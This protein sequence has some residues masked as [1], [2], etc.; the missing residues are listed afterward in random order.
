MRT[1]HSILFQHNITTQ[2]AP[3]V[4]KR[5]HVMI[6][7]IPRMEKAFTKALEDPK[8]PGMG[9]SREARDEALKF[10]NNVV[11]DGRYISV[12]AR[13]PQEAASKLKLKVS[14]EA[15]T[16][17]QAAA[18]HIHGP[19]PVEGPVEAVIAVAVVIAVAAGMPA[20]GETVIDSSAIVSHKL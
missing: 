7:A 11:T 15:L 2:E 13:A 10:Y 5:R 9:K 14:D 16:I 19:G 18:L 8:V 1:T 17:V 4:A 20:Q 12:L 6:A 3:E